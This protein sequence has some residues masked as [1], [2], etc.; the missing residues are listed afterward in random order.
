MLVII[1]QK[2]DASFFQ[3]LQDKRSSLRVILCITSFFIINNKIV[4]TGSTNISD[5]GTGGYNANIAILIENEKF[6]SLKCYSQG[7]SWW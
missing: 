1:S 4:W 2:T 3:W 6:A 7:L 5:S